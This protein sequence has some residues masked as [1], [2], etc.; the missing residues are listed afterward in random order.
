[1]PTGFLGLRQGGGQRDT[2]QNIRGFRSVKGLDTRSVVGLSLGWSLSER[3]WQALWAGQTSVLGY[4]RNDCHR[5]EETAQGARMGVGE[6]VRASISFSEVKSKE[7]HLK[8]I[9]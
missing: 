9:S 6:K 4:S 2:G 3:S 1:V 8:P 5:E 7:G